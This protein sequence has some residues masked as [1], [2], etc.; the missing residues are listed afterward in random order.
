MLK[1]LF[2]KHFLIT[3]GPTWEMLDPVRFLSNRSSG[4]MGFEIAK[5]AARAGAKVTLVT[6]PVAFADPK[7]VDVIRVVSAQEM[8]RA[9]LKHF[10]KCDVAIMTAAVS[11]YRPMKTEKH[12]LKKC[13]APHMMKDIFTLKFVRNPDILATLGKRKK[14]DQ[15]LVG[16][17]LESR[18]ILKYAKDKLRRKQ[19]DVI[20]ANAVPALGSLTNSATL[21]YKD[22]SIQK[23][24]SLTKS[25]LAVH[26]IRRIASICA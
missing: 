2:G 26:L 11:D 8:Y 1:P 6:G 19:C 20:I 16:F 13:T 7:G 9:C 22:G 15:V 10:P 25:R 12:K 18:N 5:A 14:K 24:P 23:L 3:A 21:V 4:L 17:A